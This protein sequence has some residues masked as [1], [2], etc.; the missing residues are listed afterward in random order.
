MIVLPLTFHS[1]VALTMSLCL[2]PTSESAVFTMRLQDVLTSLTSATKEHQQCFQQAVTASSI[3]ATPIVAAVSKAEGALSVLSTVARLQKLDVI[4]SR[5][6][7]SD[8]SQL[9]TLARQL[10]V[11][12]S[13]MNLYYIFI[14]QAREGFLIT[15]VPSIPA[16]PTFSSPAHS[17]PP[18]PGHDQPPGN[19]EKVNERAPLDGRT[20]GHPLA[21]HH[22]PASQVH[23]HTKTHHRKRRHLPHKHHTASHHSNHSHSSLLHLA[24]S[25]ATRTESAVGVF[26]SLNYL[27]LE[28]THMFH[29]DSEAHV[30]RATELLGTSCQDLLQSC[31]HGLQAACDWLGSVRNNRFNFWV[32]REDKQRIRM[33]GIKKYEDLHRGLSLNLDE[34][35]NRKRFFFHLIER[36]KH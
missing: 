22:Q 36:C 24:L 31:E 17:R 25:R 32:S 33:D 3:S 13:G 29:P 5:F 15:P 28:A 1:A 19:S 30:A 11:K 26:E 34:F 12:A 7:P 6:A 4:Y 21:D 23:H 27:N 8:Y 2:F 14:D 35:M 20:K 10:I 9:H 16:T 18:S